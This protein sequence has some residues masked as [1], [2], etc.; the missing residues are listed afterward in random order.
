VPPATNSGNFK[1]VR[2]R[3]KPPRLLPTM[4]STP[5]HRVAIAYRSNRT[6]CHTTGFRVFSKIRRDRVNGYFV[7]VVGFVDWSR[8]VVIDRSR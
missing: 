6:S 8:S 7:G 5:A 4:C 2:R 3:T 1:T